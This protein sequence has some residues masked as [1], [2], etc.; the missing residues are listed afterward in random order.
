MDELSPE[1]ASPPMSPPPEGLNDPGDTNAPLYQDEDPPAAPVVDPTADMDNLSDNDS[2][3][4]EVDEA[5][6]ED[7]DP[8]NIAIEDR[9]AIAVDEDNVKLLGRHKRKRDGDDGEPV[10]KKKKEG[11]REKPKKARKKRDSDDDDFSGGPELEGKRK[12]KTKNITEDGPGKKGKGR[13]RKATPENEEDMDPEERRRRALDR[14][15]DAALKN[16]TRRRRKA[17]GIDI[18][19]QIDEEVTKLRNRMAAAA[20]ADVHAR[21]EKPPRPAM[22]KLRMLPEVVSFLNRNNREAESAIVDPD[23]NLLESVRFFLEPLSDGS[24]PAYNI[25]R[26]LFAALTKL[27]IDKEA[28]K[29]SGV[30]KVVHFYTKSK[31]PEPSIKRQAERLLGEWSRPIL[32]RT[33]DFRK[34]NLQTVDYDPT[35]LPIRN[36]QGSHPMSAAQMAQE[37][38]ERVL[39]PPQRGNRA[40]FETPP[41]KT[42]SVAPISVAPIAGSFSRPLG[43]GGED[44]F[45]KMKARQAAREGKGKR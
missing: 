44:A 34:R 42:Y 10:K 26:D 3:L 40:S 19:N 22:H 11:K 4:S 9:P 23:N 2:V 6:F 18:T 8:T 25:Q 32:K 33:D 7:F 27:P 28:L 29:S 35:R 12:R 45:R 30:G 21:G 41:D 14:A 37:A 13:S 36:S 15:M 39:A 17:D 31:K 43:A 38:R 24:L 1:S 16:P 5:Q 20:E